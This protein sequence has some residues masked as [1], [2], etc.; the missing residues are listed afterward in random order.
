M[1]TQNQQLEAQE[2]VHAHTDTEK[3]HTEEVRETTAVDIEHVEVDNDPREWSPLLKWTILIIIANGAFIAG[4]ATTIYNPG[5]ANIKRDL[6]AQ[7][8][9]ISL[10]L[11]IY[12]LL[13]GIF[14]MAWSLVSEIYGRKAVYVV[15]LALATVGCIVAALAQTTSVLIGMR[16]LQSIGTCSVM[17]VG[18]GTLADIFDPHERGQKMGIFY[19]GPL[20]GPA[21]GPIIGGILTQYLSWRATFWCLVVWT[22]ITAV[23][24]IYPFRETFRKERSITYQTALLKRQDKQ[25]NVSSSDPKQDLNRIKSKAESTAEELK[26]MKLSFTDLNPIPP[27]KAI[28]S[29]W[30]NFLIILTSG[31]IYGFSY[32]I[33][34]SATLVLEDQYGYSALYVGL[35][36]LSFGIGALLGSVLG[37]RYSDYRLRKEKSLHTGNVPAEVRLRS[38]LPA[39]PL[40]PLAAIA[41]GWLAQYRCHIATLCVA[42]FFCGFLHV[43]IYTSVMAYNADANNGRVVMAAACNSLSRGLFAFIFAEICVPVRNSIGDG[44]L[45]SLWTGLWVIMGGIIVLVMLKDLAE[46]E[47]LRTA[48]VTSTDPHPSGIKKI[49][50]YAAQLVW[51][52]GKFPI[53]IG[54]DFTWYPSL[55]YDTS[56]PMS[57]NNIRFELA[58]VLFNLGALYC[59]LAVNSNRS[60][61]DGLKTAANYFML[62]AGVMSH[63]K[64]NI[65]PGM[66]STAPD[67]M[68]PMTLECL[69]N[70]LL[71]QAQECVWQKAIKDGLKD[72]SIAKLAAKVSDLYVDASDC[73]IKSDSVSSEWIHHMSV[74]HHHFA[75]AAQYRASCDCLEKGKYGEEVARLKDALACANEAL[76]EGRYVEKGVLSDLNVLKNKV[77]DDLQR[78]EKDNDMI[79]LQPVPPKAELKS[80]D[81]ANMVTA[82]VPQEAS[83]PISFLGEGAPLG[84]PLFAKLVPYSVHVAASIYVSRRDDTINSVIN[85]LEGLTQRVH[86]LMSSLNLPG[87]LQALEKPLG[88]P[89]GLVSHAEEIRQQNGPNRLKRAMEDI[90]KLKTNDRRTFQEGVNLLQTEAAED[91]QLRTKY[92]TDR[93]NRM[94]SSEAAQR[95]YGQIHEYEGYFK[96]AESSDATVRQ[97]GVKHEAQA[98]DVNPELLK[99]ASRLEREYPMQKIEAVQFEDFFDRRLQRYETDKELPEQ[100]RREQERMPPAVA[101]SGPVNA[102]WTPDMGIKFGSITTPSKSNATYDASRP[103]KFSK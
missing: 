35:V 17:A 61:A 69:E 90:D 58:N 42:L 88:L 94:L 78:A 39:L 68:D 93:W 63:L 12:I 85:E 45:Y 100:E 13:S 19:A 92:G 102:A 48:A 98:D 96:S 46:V 74:K 75:A 103:L 14:P 70:L 31:L 2:H 29:R 33:Q 32:S 44:G 91:E 37:G 86:E 54:T 66:R 87:S 51:M 20:L 76:K 22:G 21:V 80:L 57:Q 40:I 53:D 71:A 5:I 97:N 28:L 77:Q 9:Q 101:A 55:G 95:L 50:A 81:R 10:S 3:C 83:E 65:I 27:I 11:S 26:E 15:S 36:L 30:N 73:G 24:F 52:G 82:K 6:D 56:K 25:P 4:L 38:T 67:D 7:D 8:W 84:R 16:C 23:G 41:F 60:T 72:G 1:K 18:Q 49:Q 47:A 59:Q 99:E 43:W 62:A 79:Y 34:Y 64:T 89:P